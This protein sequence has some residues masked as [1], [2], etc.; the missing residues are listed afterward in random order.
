MHAIALHGHAC[1]F[2]AVAPSPA[3]PAMARLV[4]AA[5]TKFLNIEDMHFKH[6]FNLGGGRGDWPKVKQRSK[7]RVVLL[8]CCRT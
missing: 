5:G 4:F 7:S 3:G 2:R 1:P 8:Q 6:T